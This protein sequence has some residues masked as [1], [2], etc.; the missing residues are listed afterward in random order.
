[1][2]VRI[3]IFFSKKLLL[4][5]VL[6]SVILDFWVPLY[7]RILKYY[8]VKFTSAENEIIFFC[9][10]LSSY[11]PL[12]V[13]LFLFFYYSSQLAYNLQTLCLSTNSLLFFCNFNEYIFLF[14]AHFLISQAR[15][16]V[17]KNIKNICITNKTYC[18]TYLQHRYKKFHKISQHSRTICSLLKFF[19]FVYFCFGHFALLPLF[20]GLYIRF[21]YTFFMFFVFKC[22]F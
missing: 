12:F 2:F 8:S 1:M 22:Y 3:E 18:H 9:N 14:F 11:L 5:K 4:R 20:F 7:F 10:F 16:N 19:A 6:N 17:K 21:G 13:Y 15:W